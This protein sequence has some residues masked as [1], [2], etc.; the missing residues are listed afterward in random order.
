MVFAGCLAFIYL[1]PGAY[2][3]SNRKIDELLARLIVRLA[4]RI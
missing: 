1:P 4:D 2:L 3:R